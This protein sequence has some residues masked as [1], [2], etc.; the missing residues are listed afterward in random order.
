M[1]LAGQSFYLSSET[2]SEWICTEFGTDSNG[3]EMINPDLLTFF[4]I[5]APC[6]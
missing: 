3:S 2:S 4:S 5:A 1:P 6:C